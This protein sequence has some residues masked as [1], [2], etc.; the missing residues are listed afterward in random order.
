MAHEKLFW[1]NSDNTHAGTEESPPGGRKQELEGA[2]YTVV[3]TE[4]DTVYDNPI[5]DDGIREM[6][7][8]ELLPAKRE[9]LKS[10]VEAELL[11][12]DAATARSER[13]LVEGTDEQADRDRHT[14]LKSV[15]DDLRQQWRELDDGTRDSVDWPTWRL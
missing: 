1:F 4:R 3:A 14:K 9:R 13:E 8:E 15:S 5:Y 6:T 7:D 12:I 11:A 2:G 10:A